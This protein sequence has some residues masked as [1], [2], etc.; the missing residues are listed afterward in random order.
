[1]LTKEGDNEFIFWGQDFKTKKSVTDGNI[2]I[3]N[4]QDGLRELQT[5]SFNA[6]GIAK[7]TINA[8]ADIALVQRNDDRAIVPINLKYLNTD[9][10][11][12]R[13]LPKGRLTRYFI[14]T[15]RPLYRPGD[16]VYFK[17]VLRDDD[18]A[19][20]T[21]P[22]GEALVKIYSGY[23][24]GGSSI[25][26]I[27]ERNFQI[28]ADGTINGQYQLPVSAK[29]GYHTLAVSVPSQADRDNYWHSE[30]PSNT[31]SFDVQFFK[32][33]EFSIDVTTP[34]TELIAGDKTSFKISGQYFSGQS[35]INQK[36]KYTVYSA[37]FYEYQYLADQ[38]NLS[39]NLSDDYH[40]RYR[41]GNN[42]V[43]EGTATLDKNGEAEINIDST[44]NFN[45]GK[46]QVFSIEATIDDGSITPSFSRRNILVYAGEY[47]IYR[48][49][50]SYGVKVNAPLSLPVTLIPYRSNTDVGGVNLIAKIHRENWISYQ[51]EN[52]KH[53]CYRKEEE[54]LPQISIKTDGQG[55]AAFTFT[56]TKIGSYAIRV[57]GKDTRGNLISKLFHSYVSVDNQ[58]YYTTDGSND[59]T[60]AADKQ[61][62]L[63]TDTVR[64][65]IFSSIPNRDV[66]LSLERGRVN[67]FQ[68]VH[69]DG[70]NGAVEIPLVS[71][72]IPNMYAKV[73]SFS[74][75]TLDTTT[76][77]IPVSSEG[78]KLLVDITPNSKTFGPGETVTVNVSTTDVEGNPVS[79]DLALWTVDKAIFEL[80][81]IKLGD[82]F[83]TF[84]K[85]RSNTT[86]EAHSLEGI[87]VEQAEGGGCF[88]K[89]TSVLM[90]DGTLKK[91]RGC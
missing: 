41:Y 31:I 22:E 55:N 78:K 76:V 10:L 53:P 63:P 14:F 49:D 57:E 21:I 51:E 28:S 90:A 17:A 42:K 25:Q 33:P 4:L 88:A 87:L 89:G 16:T 32:K 46:S 54:D 45:K 47:G 61:K 6:E 24:Y 19:R 74:N 1:V 3:L 84:W 82:I 69:L 18:D 12:G 71:T 52:K 8:D 29:T 43:T 73:A 66:F 40:Y 72:D 79:A 77:N 62:Y 23:Y 7:G 83:N 70:K 81:D 56:P 27:F 64:L 44:I 59:L 80:S 58:P 86:Q 85:E 67:K 65:K 48:K 34:K 60:I 11:Y 38:Q 91:N 75:Y 9:Y 26:P 20:Y 37:D 15:D 2:K 36:V 68:I 30:W 5:V 39:R 50:T 35:L 13:F